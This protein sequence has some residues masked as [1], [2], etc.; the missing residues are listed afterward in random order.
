M[1]MRK[2]VG[3]DEAIEMNEALAEKRDFTAD[4]LEAF[5]EDVQAEVIDGQIFYFAAPKVI[6]QRLSGN[7][8]IS[9]SNHIAEKKGTCEAFIA[10]VAVRLNCDDKTLVEPDVIVV[11][12]KDKLHGDGCYGAP[13]L[14]IEVTSKFTRKRDYGLK[15][16]KYRI[17][18][19]KEYWIVDPE[20]ETVMVNCFD[21]ECQTCL[22]SF[23]DEIT[24]HLFPE[25]R[26][27]VRDLIL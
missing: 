6:H 21:D 10:P 24:F 11:C 25:L 26:V 4:D 20:R 7:L 9:I 5:P 13:D 18:G 22:Y 17:A 12:D 14:V 16:M 27:R 8:F 15:M 2:P 19:V 1:C 3:E 23:D